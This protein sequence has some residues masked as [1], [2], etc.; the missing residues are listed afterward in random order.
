MKT[1]PFVLVCLGATVA[2]A[3][4]SRPVAEPKWGERVRH[5]QSRV[6]I[7]DAPAGKPN[8][9]FT[10]QLRNVGPDKIP[11]T[12]L[13]VWFLLAQGKD[14]VFYTALAKTPAD[15]PAAIDSGDQL[16][17]KTDLSLLDTFAYD[18]AIKIQDGIPT[19]GPDQQ[20]KKL[21]AVKDTLPVGRVRVRAFVVYDTQDG[22]KRFVETV[23]SA[24]AELG[25]PPAAD[26]FA[27]L[28]EAERKAV[29]EDL[30]RLFQGDAVA[31]K[32]AHDKAV[33]IGAPAVK[34][35]VE[36]LEKE[37]ATSEHGRMWLV[38]SLLS[39]RDDRAVDA[40][41]AEVKKGG[42]SAHVIAYHGPRMNN[43][44]L[45]TVIREAAATGKDPRFTAWAARGL[46][47]AGGKIDDAWI[48]PLLKQTDPLGRSEAA[49]I[50]AGA[51]SAKAT[52]AFIKLCDDPDASVR[53]AAAN[54]AA[55]KNRKESAVIKAL[56]ASLKRDDAKAQKAAM[57]ALQKLTGEKH[58]TPKDWLAYGEKLK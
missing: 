2:I 30:V 27:T 17:F 55:Q 49:T 6:I 8:L 32:A 19:P 14:K 29:L 41:I 33:K 46:G 51:S 40:L 15:L 47:L 58:S 13:R 38:A 44:E 4:T 9:E 39:I 10:V 24:T 26:D 42:G 16:Q 36:L 20:P 11:V 28:S 12:N 37:D 5:C 25:A 35:L 21:G 56:I 43:D 3:Q 22:N 57:G 34:T 53:T 1:L 54:A 7:P 31:G 18:P 45:N 48:D 23:P 50:L 52:A